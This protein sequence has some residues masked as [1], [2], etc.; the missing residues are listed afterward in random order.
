MEIL[1]ELDVNVS[2][3]PVCVEMVTKIEMNTD[4]KHKT[5]D[6]EAVHRW[7]HLQ[8]MVGNVFNKFRS[9]FS[10]KESPVNFFWGGF[11]L[12][13]TVF[14]GKLIEP[15]PEFDLIY[16]IAMDAE[17][18]SIGFWPGNDEAPEPVFVAYTYPRPEG[19]ENAAVNPPEAK[20]SNEKGEFILPYE[21]VRTGDPEKLLLEFCES[22][23]RAGVRACC[24]DKKTL[25]HKP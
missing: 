14:S 7:W 25:E 12:M 2:I 13:I 18:T 17:Q 24:W 6:E 20:W 1:K 22:A 15:R 19:I 21:A 16:R 3:N 5:Y 11:D 10:G 4:H 8:I 23:Y 9:R